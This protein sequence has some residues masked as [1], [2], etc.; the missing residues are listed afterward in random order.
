MGTQT[1][2]TK[3]TDSEIAGEII[4]L[5]E[6]RGKIRQYNF[7][8]ENVWSSIDAQIAVLE[9]RLSSEDIHKAYEGLDDSDYV[10]FAALSAMEWMLGYLSD[11][12]S[13]SESWSSAV[14]S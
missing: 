10:L 5:K 14:G 11:D 12:E 8:G 1:M 3:K 13:P 7:F 2:P 9:K 6:I 4:L